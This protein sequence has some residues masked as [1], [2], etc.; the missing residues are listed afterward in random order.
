MTPS[1]SLMQPKYLT[2]AALAYAVIANSKKDQKVSVTEEY[3]EF[4]PIPEI[5][6][7]SHTVNKRVVPVVI[8][9]P[10]VT[11]HHTATTTPRHAKVSAGTMRQLESRRRVRSAM[12]KYQH[13]SPKT[14]AHI[15]SGTSITGASVRKSPKLTTPKNTVAKAAIRT[16]DTA[17]T[18]PSS[19]ATSPPSIVSCLPVRFKV[20]ST[21]TGT[22]LRFQCVPTYNN[23]L[24]NILERLRTNSKTSSLWSSATDL[25]TSDSGLKIQFQDAEN[26]WCT[27]SNDDD[28]Q[29]AVEASL[30]RKDAM[31]RLTIEEH[32]TATRV[33]NSLSTSFGW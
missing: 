14:E 33:W 12:E 10:V 24:Q 9:S 21:T 25:I 18:S 26:D 30:G 5:E 32:D 28:V 31:V 13:H 3:D 8:K 17:A 7:E 22:V 2:A 4:D 19:V 20:K 29:D 6:E 1:L 23:L 11:H 15:S 16:P 27:L